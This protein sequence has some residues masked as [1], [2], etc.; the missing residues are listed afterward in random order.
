MFA[1][2]YLVTLASIVEGIAAQ[3]HL[4]KQSW[5]K[6]FTPIVLRTLK[7]I[8]ATSPAAAL[9]GPIARGDVGTIQKHIA[10]LSS[11][12]YKH[13]VPPYAV[14]GVAT[15]RIVRKKRKHVPKEWIPTR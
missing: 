2:N 3:I 4:P 11:K 9:T 7:N 10:A 8:E 5:K 15:T 14:L 6:I 12:K 13:L 1:S